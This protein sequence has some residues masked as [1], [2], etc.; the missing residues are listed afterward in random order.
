M[1]RLLPVLALA[2]MCSAT[3]VQADTDQP[4]ECGLISRDGSR[5]FI[6]GMRADPSEQVRFGD[7]Q[8]GTIRQDGLEITLRDPYFVTRITII[9]AGWVTAAGIGIGMP[10]DKV[11]QRLP[12]LADDDFSPDTPLWFTN[13]NAMDDPGGMCVTEIKLDD[14]NRVSTISM[15]HAPMSISPARQP[16]PLP[17]PSRDK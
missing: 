13:P 12:A 7:Q 9:D 15:W 1:K 8:D 3:T 4:H 2:A 14:Q 17:P 16:E 11:R 5:T 6:V 10:R